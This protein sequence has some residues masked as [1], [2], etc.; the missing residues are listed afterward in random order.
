MGDDEAQSGH[1]ES[2]FWELPYGRNLDCL[3]P[4]NND[5]IL[6]KVSGFNAWENKGSDS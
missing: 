5:R 6:P 1:N 3:D 2:K 4:R